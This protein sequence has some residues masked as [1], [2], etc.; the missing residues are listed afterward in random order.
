ML[1][2]NMYGWLVT[3][4]CVN[5]CGLDVCINVRWSLCL[6]VCINAFSFTCVCVFIWFWHVCDWL[7]AMSINVY[8]LMQVVKMLRVNLHVRMHMT[9][10]KQVVCDEVTCVQ[11]YWLY[12]LYMYI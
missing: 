6:N 4:V 8:I 9:V 3:C 2:I 11:E 1:S 5:A 12:K 7:H 10:Y